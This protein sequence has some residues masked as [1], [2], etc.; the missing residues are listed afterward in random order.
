[1]YVRNKFGSSRPFLAAYAWPRRDRRSEVDSPT[2]GV[3]RRPNPCFLRAESMSGLGGI[4]NRGRS[5]APVPAVLT[6]VTLGSL[7]PW[8]TSPGPLVYL[9][10]A[11]ALMAE[12]RR[13]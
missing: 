3:T 10:R 1:M 2:P 9:T 12:G 7:C 13:C 11:M 8:C 4:A 6:G 5:S